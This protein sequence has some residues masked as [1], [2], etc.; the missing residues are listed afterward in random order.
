MEEVTGMCYVLCLMGINKQQEFQFAYSLCS[1]I[2]PVYM[3]SSLHVWDVHNGKL[4]HTLIGHTEE[5]EVK[6]I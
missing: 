2:M 1:T 6:S 5:I 3:C 4:I